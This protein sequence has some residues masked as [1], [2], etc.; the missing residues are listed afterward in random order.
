MSAA[1]EL[2]LETSLSIEGT[3]LKRDGGLIWDQLPRVEQCRRICGVGAAL[4]LHVD[5]FRSSLFVLT[6]DSQSTRNT[7]TSHNTVGFS[8]TDTTY[9]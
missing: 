2:M 9:G 5:K 3:C 6:N 4:K 8:L 1:G 7:F